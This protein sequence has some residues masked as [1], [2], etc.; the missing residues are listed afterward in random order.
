MSSPKP[1]V[2]SM[3]G[4]VAM[5]AAQPDWVPLPA[6]QHSAPASPVSEDQVPPSPQPQPLLQPEAGGTGGTARLASTRDELV[7]ST[8]GSNPNGVSPPA[9]YIEDQY[10]KCGHP[11][12]GKAFTT[13]GHMKRHLTVHVPHSMQKVQCPICKRMVTSLRRH[14]FRASCLAEQKLLSEEQ[15]VAAGISRVAK[16]PAR[17]EIQCGVCKL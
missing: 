6:I 8:P 11:G 17:S 5:H 2:V 4:E 15:L 3:D 7:E 16:Q 12:C 9:A 14:Q 13:S 10:L 1:V